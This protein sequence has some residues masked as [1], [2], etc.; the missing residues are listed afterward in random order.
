MFTSDFTTC[1]IDKEAW[2]LP[3]NSQADCNERHSVVY[4]Y[5]KLSLFIKPLNW[6]LV[7]TRFNY[8]HKIEHLIIQCIAFYLNSVYFIIAK[9]MSGSNLSLWYTL[10]GFIQFLCSKV[11]YS[12]EST[13]INWL[14]YSLYVSWC[15]KCFIFA[16]GFHNLTGI[17]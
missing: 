13:K 8:I 3:V 11:C 7:F 15:W 17:T 9:D 5:L 10:K 14:L 4:Q 2:K 12:S 1:R 16:M 6:C